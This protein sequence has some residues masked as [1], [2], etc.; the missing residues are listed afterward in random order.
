MSDRADYFTF[1][2]FENFDK[3]LIEIIRVL[4]PRGILIILET[5]IPKNKI[6][7]LTYNLYTKF[8][9]PVIGFIFSKKFYAYNYL[10]KSAE[11]F[12]YGKSFNNILK[13]NGFIDIEDSPQTLG[14]ASIYFAKKT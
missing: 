13:K 2:D 8:I 6:V 5:A 3:A 14:V 11:V 10:Y 9:M 1:L 12:P 4:K 7:R